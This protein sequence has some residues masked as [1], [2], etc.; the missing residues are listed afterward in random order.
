MHHY[1]CMRS[2]FA[3]VCFFV[4]Q[5]ARTL[6]PPPQ[7]RRKTILTEALNDVA[8][9][10]RVPNKQLRG[11]R[12]LTGFASLF[13]VSTRKAFLRLRCVGGGGVPPVLHVRFCFPFDFIF[14]DWKRGCRWTALHGRSF[15]GSRQANNSPHKN[16]SS[17]SYKKSDDALMARWAKTASTKAILRAPRAFGIF[18]LK[19]RCCVHLTRAPLPPTSGEIPRTCKALRYERI[20]LCAP[21]PC[22]HLV[23]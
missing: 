2:Y 14:P 10:S 11:C 5:V 18:L 1:S 16:H 7:C 20:F 23:L 19:F 12:H 8:F 17:S 22:F 9:H 6:S 21:A 15:T 13:N 4:S 3:L